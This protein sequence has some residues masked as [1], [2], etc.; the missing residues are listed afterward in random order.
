[1]TMPIGLHQLSPRIGGDKFYTVTDWD[2]SV[3]MIVKDENV[4]IQTRYQQRNLSFLCVRVRFQC[5]FLNELFRCCCRKLQLRRET[6]HDANNGCRREQHCFWNVQSPTHGNHDRRRTNRM[7]K[8][9][10]EWA[11]FLLRLNNRLREHYS[12][13]LIAR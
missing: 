9:R 6:M 10:M 8:N 13:S 11:E 2:F 7:P 4:G 1:M 3:C 5:H 12:V